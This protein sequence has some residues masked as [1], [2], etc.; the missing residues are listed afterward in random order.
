MNL[1]TALSDLQKIRSS[2]LV[3]RWSSF[4][5][6]V[7]TGRKTV[8]CAIIFLSFL[9]IMQSFTYLVIT[10]LHYYST[11]EY[12]Y[13]Y[14]PI[15]T[16]DFGRVQKITVRLKRNTWY[17]ILWLLSIAV[18]QL[19]LNT[20]SLK[21]RPNAV[22]KGLLG[23]QSHIVDWGYIRKALNMSVLCSALEIIWIYL[24]VF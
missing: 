15:L 4:V 11:I 22:I 13:F 24:N 17:F 14:P 19:A 3:R 10:L 1:S 16:F 12:R 7:G 21:N 9:S 8:H 5:R 2:Q 18:E 20:P 23:F 6:K